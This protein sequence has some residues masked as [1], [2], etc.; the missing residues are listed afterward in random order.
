M[1][2]KDWST[3]ASENDTAGSITWAE[4]Q[5]PNT[6]N[7]SARQMM[8]DVRTDRDNIEWRDWGHTPVY[9]DAD[10]FT[11][12]STSNLTTV[13]SVGRRLKITDA[14]TLYAVITSSSYA[15][16]TQTVNLLLDSGS[17]SAS[18]SAVAL[19]FDRANSPVGVAGAVV[20]RSSDTSVIDGFDYNVYFDTT[21]YD[22]VG[23]ISNGA[24]TEG[25]TTVITVPSGYT[26]MKIV[27]NIH[28][29]NNATG[30][31]GISVYSTNSS[32]DTE[33]DLI[34]VVFVTSDSA[35][36]TVQTSMQVDTGWRRVSAGQYY[37]VATY[38]TS[39]GVLSI[40]NGS[41]FSVE[42]T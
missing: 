29:T 39:G 36:S 5:N 18:L 8:A 41:W 19:G 21:T 16:T 24:A 12:S 42:F 13:Y 27:A 30:L 17:L 34:P 40:L 10:T 11:I 7:D 14:S 38:Q 33:T 1:A 26:F 23:C 3:T 4:G 28:F 20:R 22:T 32:G 6:V 25:T 9:S 37:K 35:S 2:M 31:R 15:G